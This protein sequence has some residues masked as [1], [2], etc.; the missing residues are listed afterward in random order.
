MS[1]S[2]KVQVIDY[3]SYIQSEQTSAIK[4]ELINGELFAMTGG[5]IRHDIIKNNL[6]S[7][8]N[9]H[10]RQSPCLVLGSDANLRV[11]S[12]RH[13]NGYYP[14]VMVCCEPSDNQAYYRQKPTLV[15]EVLS[16]TSRITDKSLKKADYFSISSL[17]EYLLIEQDQLE[18]MI[19]RRLKSGWEEEIC[20][21]G[22][23]ICL[24]SIDFS[25]GIE[26]LYLKTG[27]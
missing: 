20:H 2:R 1:Q 11:E 15:A 23:L 9:Q 18:V 7:A 19:Y 4:H 22:D 24:N 6:I 3:P 12:I 10:L 21:K 27:L 13:E 14:D 5:S 16:D 25:C 17:Q 8:L 26:Y